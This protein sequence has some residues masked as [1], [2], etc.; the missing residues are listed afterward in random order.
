MQIVIEMSEDSKSV[1]AKWAGKPKRLRSGMVAAARHGAE[2]LASAISEKELGE[3]GVLR[4]VTGML[5]RSVAGRI[6]SHTGD[7]IVAG[8]GVIKGPATKYARIHEK[9]G[10]IR[11]KGG[12]ALAMPL[13]AART[14]SGKPRF[15]GG[16][17]EAKQ[18][19]PDLFML[20]RRGRPPLLV[21]P[22]RMRGGGAHGKVKALE[23]LFIL[24]K[25]VR[26]PARKW[27]S[28]GITKHREVFVVNMQRELT[29][30][31]EA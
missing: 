27:L 29:R 30:L 16:P 5:R 18:K 14:P 8:V 17:A 28:G 23:P 7:A 26:M 31:L 13:P 15:P 21:R 20:K 2:L 12:G 24:L 11:A 4:V 10:V 19:Y 1:I 6:V 9:G 25:S 3:G 22:L